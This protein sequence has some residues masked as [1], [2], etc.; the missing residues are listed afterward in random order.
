MKIDRLLQ[1]TLGQIAVFQP[2]SPKT[3][4]LHAGSRSEPVLIGLPSIRR[5]RSR[6]ARVGVPAIEAL[7]KSGR[8][9]PKVAARGVSNIN[10]A[11]Y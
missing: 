3:R 1:E 7:C 5:S 6:R 11:V 10:K 9:I 4:E 2:F 8:D